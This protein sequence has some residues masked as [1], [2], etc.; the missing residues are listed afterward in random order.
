MK[1]EFKKVFKILADH[2][3]RI[4]L[5]EGKGAVKTKMKT[6]TWYRAG[7]TTE[8]I[9]ML[10]SAGFF[11]EPKSISEIIEKLKTKDFYLKPSDLTLPLRKIVRKGLLSRTKQRA[12]GSKS[13]RWLYTKT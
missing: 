6:R 3:R 13:K 2:E 12:D 5:I 8:K 7:S 9:M 1:A 10:L 11:N 4:A